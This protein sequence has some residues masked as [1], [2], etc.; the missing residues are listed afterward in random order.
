MVK[1]LAALSILNSSG[2]SPG[3]TRKVAALV[4][5]ALVVAALVYRPLVVAALVTALNTI[6]SMVRP[7]DF[8]ANAEDCGKGCLNAMYNESKV[9]PINSE[10]NC[11]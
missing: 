10:G 3:A 4:Y 1:I 8:L 5:R 6:Y 11:S 7:W 2:P 9:H